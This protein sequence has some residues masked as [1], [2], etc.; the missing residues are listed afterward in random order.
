VRR[1]GGY[2]RE[3]PVSPADLTAT[4]LHHLGIDFTQE[5]VDEFQK[6]QNRLSE[7]RPVTDLG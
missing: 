2:V 7:G 6:L 3:R 5:Y 4:V 1:Y